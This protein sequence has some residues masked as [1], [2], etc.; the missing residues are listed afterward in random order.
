[1]KHSFSWSGQRTSLEWEDF[2]A[3]I[4]ISSEGISHGSV[5]GDSIPGNENQKD[6]G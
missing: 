1:M 3:L 6:L 2:W 4:L 5:Y